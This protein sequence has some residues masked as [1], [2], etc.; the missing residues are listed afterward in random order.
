[1]SMQ[2]QLEKWRDLPLNAVFGSE[3]DFPRAAYPKLHL[4]VLKHFYPDYPLLP[5]EFLKL[6]PDTIEAGFQAPTVRSFLSSGTSQ[7]DRSR[8]S[9]SNEGIALYHEFSLL[10]FRAMLLP[11]FK[12]ET[13]PHGYSM[14]P[15]V[16]EWPTSSL[17]QMVGWISEEF[18]V[19]Y[20]NEATPLSAEDKPVWLFATGFH[21]VAFADA[22]G[23]FPLPKGSI[24]IETG[25]TKGKTRSVTREE[26][27]ELIE[28]CFG[29]DKN[30]IVS[31]YGMCELASQA[32]DF[33]DN[34]SGPILPMDKRWFRFPSWAQ[35][36]VLSPSQTIE[37]QGDGTLIIDDRIRA[38]I[39]T[40]FRTEDRVLLKA[41]ESFQLR[42]RVAFS[43]LKGCS[44]F[45]E[46]LLKS[47]SKPS[48]SLNPQ[49]IRK[50]LHLESAAGVSEERA[51]TIHKLAQ[52]MLS[53][54]EFLAKIETGLKH[55]QL[56][57]WCL[58]D[59]KASIPQSPRGWLKAGIATKNSAESW[60]LIPPRTHDFAV[61]HPLFMAALLNLRLVVRSTF[62]APLLAYWARVFK[63]FWT[64]E[65]L[66]P[67]WRLD[68][69]E[70]LPCHSLMVFGSDETILTLRDATP[71][72]VQGFGNWIT[73]SIIHRS[74]WTD[75]S[76]VKDAFSLG[77]EGCM[78]SRLLVVWDDQAPDSLAP[79]PVTIG[80][81]S[82]GEHLHLAHSELDMALGGWELLPRS[83]LDSLVIGHREWDAE[84]RVEDLLSS[85]PLTLPVVRSSRADVAAIFTAVANNKTF[86]LVSADYLSQPLL[87]RHN[88][89]AI[90][91]IGQAN[92]AKWTGK[93][94]GQSL[95]F[96]EG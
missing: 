36:K 10:S 68:S 16:D 47:S 24:V 5:I 88:L 43:P 9:F 55:R 27:F 14:I 79:Q 58:S 21:I 45:A 89:P 76:W 82:H 57:E 20:W 28:K 22:S 78:S 38:D 42:G 19:T 92:A 8:S 25:G 65:T 49:L 26:S 35:T 2:Q 77:Q 12:S 51:K 46:D 91:E 30:H 95:F 69:G 85:R 62:D 75:N 54:P 87:A 4:G 34:P 13:R 56:A 3:A 31:E 74:S 59:L 23:R 32:Y 67:S 71:Q 40:P 15:S 66:D 44:L 96:P 18:P 29:V 84:L 53:D 81:L 63:A 39:G 94:G 93:H 50:A 83:S 90:C 1:M 11:F 17:A 41:D 64:F 72:P 80:P 73:I 70:A 52:W 61:M 33:V 7:R 37:G 86:K 48:L 60:L 6:Y